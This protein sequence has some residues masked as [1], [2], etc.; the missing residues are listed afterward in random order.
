MQRT[1][2]TG[3]PPPP[4]PE[5]ERD[6]DDAIVVTGSRMARPDLEAPSPVTTVQAQRENLGNLKLYRIPIP[7]SVGSNSQKQVALLTQ[8]RVRFATEYQWAQRFDYL[9]EEPEAAA[10][11]LLFTNVEKEGLGLPLPAGSFTFYAMR[12]GQPFLLGEG[13]MTDRAVNEKVEVPLSDTPGV[14][15]MQ[16]QIADR[17]GV[18]EIE[19]VVTNDLSHAVRF[20]A[21]TGGQDYL[22]V[23]SSLK[24]ERDRSDWRWRVTL[25]AN[26]SKTLRIRYRDP[27]PGEDD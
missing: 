8:P 23:G 27:S 14:R 1:H 16:R 15:V 7:V 26:G 5:Y 11:T 18:K 10:Q 24:L 13:E 6:G 12:G 25:P 17:D 21:W 22:L 9:T 20:S 19:L 3:Y 4:P 2:Q